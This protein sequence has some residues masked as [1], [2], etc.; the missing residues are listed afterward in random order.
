MKNERFGKAT[1]ENGWNNLDIIKGYMKGAEKN[2]AH[3][4]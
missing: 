1:R 2:F 4:L 3:H